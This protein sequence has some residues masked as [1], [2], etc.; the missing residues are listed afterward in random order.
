MRTRGDLHAP[1][2]TLDESDYDPR[3]DTTYAVVLSENATRIAIRRLSGPQGEFTGSRSGRT[4]SR[5]TFQVEQWAGG[6]F[7]VWPG[8]RTLQGELTLYGSGVPIISSERGRL[9]RQ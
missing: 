5:I 7:V 9:V 1:A 4:S 2:D 6:R 8:E 3:P